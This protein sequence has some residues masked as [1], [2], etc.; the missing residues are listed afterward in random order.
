MYRLTYSGLSV[1]FKHTK[2]KVFT[3]DM[4]EFSV[5]SHRSAFCSTV[6]Y[7]GDTV[8]EAASE[9]SIRR[10]TVKATDDP[11]L[12][13]PGK[14]FGSS[15]NTRSGMRIWP[16]QKSR[17]GRLLYMASLKVQCD[18]VYWYYQLDIDW[19]SED[20]ADQI[21]QQCIDHKEDVTVERQGGVLRNS[22]I[23][24]GG[25]GKETWHYLVGTFVKKLQ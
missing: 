4:A 11:W 17:R 10:P 1:S 18:Q 23:H 24:P 7:L 9:S 5:I 2:F 8:I 14:S 22:D 25:L 16:L 19:E 15:S 6:C 13:S 21:G 12:W 20:Q 3:I